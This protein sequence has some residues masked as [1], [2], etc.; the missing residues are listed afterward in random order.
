MAVTNAECVFLLELHD[1]EE[2]FTLRRDAVIIDQTTRRN[3]GEDLNLQQHPCKNLKV[4][5]N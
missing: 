2:G 5:Q 4:S 3:V 1:S